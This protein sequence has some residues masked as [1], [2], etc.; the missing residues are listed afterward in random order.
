M[1]CGP[2]LAQAPPPPAKADTAARR[3]AAGNLVGHGGPVKAI[4]VSAQ[5]THALTGSFDY[6]MMLWQIGRAEPRLIRRFDQHG[7]PVNA[8]A[9]VERA[10]NGVRKLLSAGDD[11]IVSVWDDDGKLIH[12]FEGHQGKIVALDVDNSGRYAVSAGWDRT[13]RIWDLET[14]KPGPVLSAHTG[15]VNAVAFAGATGG[16]HNGRSEP[17]PSETIFTA[18]YDGLLRAFDRQTGELKRQVHS[19]GQSINAMKRLSSGTRPETSPRRSGNWSHVYEDHLVFGTVSGQSGIVDGRTGQQIRAFPEAPRPILAVAEDGERVAIASGDGLIRIF[20]ERDGAPIE[21]YRNSFGPVWALSFA[22]GAPDTRPT[23]L[24]YGGLDDFATLWQVSPRKPFEDVDATKYP[25][26]FQVA[27]KPDDPLAKGELQ[28]ARK[29]SICHT[30]TP[31]GANRAG[32]T[33][34]SVFGRKIATLPG[35]PF[36]ADLKKLDIVWTAD[37]IAKL[38]ELGPD[39]FTPGSKMPL[40]VMQDTA[41]RDAL[42]AFLEVA[43]R[44]A[45]VDAGAPN[46]QDSTQQGDKKP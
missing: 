31:D 7:G 35:Y 27:G 25:R 26:R 30:L 22:T 34:H 5:G 28:F 37:T 41:E 40:Q 42:I 38:F 10:E 46:R 20:N 2:A 3:A 12:R 9:F 4:A 18:S 17:R 36:S 33:L 19:A 16:E 13:A 43:T 14:L 29:C 1:L 32:P 45:P 21:E 23:K 6:A 39:K 8:V 24:Y 44:A 15:P 11:G